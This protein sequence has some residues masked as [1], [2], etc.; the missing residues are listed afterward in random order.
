VTGGSYFAVTVVTAFGIALPVWASGGDAFVGGLAAEALVLG[1]AGGA[2]ASTTRLVLAG[3][4]TAIALHAGP[5]TLLI[6]FAEET[7]SLYSSGPRTLNPR[8]GP[9]AVRA[10]PVIGLIFVAAVLLSRRLDLLSLGDDA[11]SVLGV[12]IRSTRAIGILLAV[13]LTATAVPLAGPIGFVGLCSP[14]IARLLSRP[15]PVLAKHAVLIPVTANTG[16]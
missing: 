14:V 7:T 12:R 11:A 6:L 13:V 5:S 1:L 4:A 9:A 10:L 3:P 2:A 16:A 8:A 15:V